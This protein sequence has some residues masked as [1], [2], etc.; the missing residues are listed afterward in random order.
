[1]GSQAQH[2]QSVQG[3]RAHLTGNGTWAHERHIDVSVSELH[4]QRVEV[5]LQTPCEQLKA[6]QQPQQQSQQPQQP[7]QPQQQPQQPQHP[8][9]PIDSEE[10][11]SAHTCVACLAALYALEHG[12]PTL[13]AART[14]RHRHAVRVKQ[15]H[16]ARAPRYQQCWR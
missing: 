4:A 2:A 3:S 10:A 5:P 12:E 16:M 14:P 1:M 13:P 9:Q 8:Q 15:C 11:V 6:T 7:Q